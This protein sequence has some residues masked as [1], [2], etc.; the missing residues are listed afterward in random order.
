MMVTKKVTCAR[1]AEEQKISVTSLRNMCPKSCGTKNFGNKFEKHVTEKRRDK[2]RTGISHFFSQNK[3]AT[4]T[5]FRN[6]IQFRAQ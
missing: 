6:S 3:K 2:G 5:E 1:K 4:A